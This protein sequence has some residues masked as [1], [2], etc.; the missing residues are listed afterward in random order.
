M[1][2][3]SRDP[4]KTL[5]VDACEGVNYPS[6]RNCSSKLALDSDTSSAAVTFDS[7]NLE[8]SLNE[9]KRFGD[10]TYMLK[11]VECP[12]NHASVST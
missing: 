4:F 5:V 3:V 10:V 7:F 12:T 8:M 6:Y 9:L 1:V 2:L 11:D